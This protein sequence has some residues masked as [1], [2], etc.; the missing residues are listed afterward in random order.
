MCVWNDSLLGAQSNY[1]VYNNLMYTAFPC[2][3][4][5]KRNTTKRG[6]Q[7]QLELPNLSQVHRQ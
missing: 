4:I 7:T 3:L 2:K 1:I 5:D 6:Q